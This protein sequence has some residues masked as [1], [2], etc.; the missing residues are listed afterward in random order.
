[1]KRKTMKDIESGVGNLLLA[2][3]QSGA[4][5]LAAIEPAKHDSDWTKLS[6][7]IILMSGKQRDCDINI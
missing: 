3:P 5:F 6:L 7:E 2:A 4:K 1:M